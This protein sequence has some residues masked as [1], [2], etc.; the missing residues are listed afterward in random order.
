M[1]ATRYAKLPYA[2]NFLR[3]FCERLTE[4]AVN[5]DERIAIKRPAVAQ[6]LINQTVQHVRGFRCAQFVLNRHS[7]F[8]FPYNTV[9][10][11]ET[12]S[13]R[14]S[15]EVA[16]WPDILVEGHR[17]GIVFFRVGRREIG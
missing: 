16:S 3:Q 5:G 17:G 1:I 15:R 8:S 9:M 13:E 11:R 10:V 14:I 7:C 12:V 2:C 6:Q 4:Q